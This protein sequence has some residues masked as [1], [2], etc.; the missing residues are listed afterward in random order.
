MKINGIAISSGNVIY[1]YVNPL[2]S[3]VTGTATQ[4][5]VQSVLIAANDFSSIDVMK[6]KWRV[7]KLV[8]TG[9]I[10]MRI[11]TNTT[12][13]LTGAVE[14]GRYTLSSGFIWATMDRTFELR[15]NLISGLLRSNAGSLTDTTIIA[16]AGSETSFNTTVNN[17]IIF[18]IT[19]TASTD[20]TT[21]RMVNITNS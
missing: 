17:Y 19:Q 5:I 3:T 9:N 7:S 10:S 11:Y 15:D 16:S 12:N 1:K 14:L 4:T 13:S 20:V 2:T 21:S 18:T 6:I 8:S